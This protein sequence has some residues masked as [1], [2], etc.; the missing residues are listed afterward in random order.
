M[1]S[2][3]AVANNDQIVDGIKEGVYD[4][5]VEAMMLFQGSGEG[6]GGEPVIEL[7][8][9]SDAETLYK[10]VKKGERKAERRFEAVVMV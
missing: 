10:A 5:V 7:T 2:R 8:V 1:G 6:N 3:S 9:I 4:A